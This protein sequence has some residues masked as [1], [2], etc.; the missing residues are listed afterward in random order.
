MLLI[1]CVPYVLVAIFCG[2]NKTMKKYGV[3]QA[4]VTVVGY[5]FCDEPIP[6]RTTIHGKNVTL[7]QFK[8]HIAKKGNYRFVPCTTIC[9]H[10][11]EDFSQFFCHMTL[12]KHGIMVSATAVISFCLSVCLSQHLCTASKWLNISSEFFVV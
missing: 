6:Y 2:S 11:M 10:I 4:V 1:N 3:D 7:G 8:Q 5:Y 9:I 12:C